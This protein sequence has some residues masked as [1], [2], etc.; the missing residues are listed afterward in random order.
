MTS[1]SLLIVIH[2][3]YIHNGQEKSK[4][5]IM[6]ITV[7]QN[8]FFFIALYNWKIMFIKYSFYLLS[9]R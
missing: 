9:Y 5:K 3:L 2:R 8:K 7:K 6:N 4:T 1:L